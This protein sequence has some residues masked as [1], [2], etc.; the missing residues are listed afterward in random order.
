MSYLKLGKEEG[1]DYY[2][3]ESKMLEGDLAGRM[4]IQY[5]F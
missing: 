3:V 1:A 4:Y 5:Y 2:A